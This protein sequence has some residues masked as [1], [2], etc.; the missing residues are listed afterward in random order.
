MSSTPQTYN[1]ARRSLHA[2]RLPLANA[3]RQLMKL[4]ELRMGKDFQQALASEGLW[5]L[6]PTSIEV[7]QINVGKLCNQTCRHCH[8]DAGPDRTEV[9]SRETAEECVAA[10]RRNAI[11]SVDITGGAPELNPNFRWLVEQCASLGR[12]V[13]NRCNLTIL[14]TGP[15][16]D[17]PEFFA[18]HRVELVCSL[19]HYQPTCTDVQR[20]DG[21]FEKSIRVLRRLNEL[22]YGD[23][24]SGLRL[25]L[26]TNPVGAVLPAPQ[27]S[28]E[29]E[30]KRELKRLHDVSFD[31]LYTITNMPISRY[32]DWLLETGNLEGYM[33]RL[34]ESFNP[35]A[36]HG[37]MCRNTISVG[38]DGRLYDCDFNQ[39]LDI[40]VSDDAVGHVR[41]FDLAALQART[42]QTNRHC[43]GCTAGTGSSCTGKTL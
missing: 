2:R 10:L 32:L 39:M 33:R 27:T 17:L 24:R 40:A 41:D 20:G 30:W 25:V 31:A 29:T 3:G 37:V 6:Q 9:M 28:L 14:E 15:H 43:F 1:L 34:V 21:V 4:G 35:Q 12:H 11:P 22:G 8:V 42:I 5:P 19:P 13:I 23:G 26:V 16:R 7:L 38:W 18:K 36:A